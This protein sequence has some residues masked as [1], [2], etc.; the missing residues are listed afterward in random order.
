[1]KDGS[2]Y[3][4]DY[5]DFTTTFRNQDCAIGW[6]DADYCPENGP[7]GGYAFFPTIGRN[8]A[9]LGKFSYRSGS[10]DVI[11][12]VLEEATGQPLAELI[13]Q[14]VW[15]PMGAEFDAF[16]TVDDSGFAL[17]DHGM[18]S[19]LR[20]L[21]RV[22]QL[23]LNKG[24]AL[25]EQ[26]VPPEFV[27]DIRDQAGDPNWPDPSPEGLEP[28]YRSFWWGKGNEQRHLIGSGIHGQT[29]LVAPNEGIV[30]AMYSTWPRA[31]GND[32]TAFWEAND[33]FVDTVVARFR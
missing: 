4:E 14:H 12:W 25:G 23:M 2:D 20:D 21:G 24:V 3:T 33:L 8:E 15:K 9:K 31:D 19:T 13:S 27:E 28:Y 22:G 10:T 11:G 30:V 6:T 5:P 29:L 16:I 26:V 32:T 18:N 1:M 17:A 7:R